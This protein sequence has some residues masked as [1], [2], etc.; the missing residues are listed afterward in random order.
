[1][2]VALPVIH[3]LFTPEKHRQRSILASNKFQATR[4]NTFEYKKWPKQ[5]R[6]RYKICLQRASFFSFSKGVLEHCQVYGLKKSINF[7]SLSILSIYFSFQTNFKFCYLWKKALKES[8]IKSFLDRSKTF[9][10]YCKMRF[11]EDKIF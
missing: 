3:C 8:Q 9:L 10:F 4:S 1:M 5:Q 7:S 6:K 2:Y 11:L